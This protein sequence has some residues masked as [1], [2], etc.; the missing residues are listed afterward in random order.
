MYIYYLL[1]MYIVFTLFVLPM[2]MLLL[3][4][5]IYI[6]IYY[7]YIYPPAHRGPADCG[8]YCI[9]DML[10]RHA[11]IMTTGSCYWLLQIS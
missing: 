10:S 6:Y 8:G 11:G 3:L 9:P 1:Y 4:Y 5:Y 7:T 2:P